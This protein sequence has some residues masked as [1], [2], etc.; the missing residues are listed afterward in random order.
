MAEFSPTCTNVVSTSPPLHQFIPPKYKAFAMPTQ[1][2]CRPR[3]LYLNLFLQ[4]TRI[5]PCQYSCVVDLASFASVHSK[6]SGLSRTHTVVVSVHSKVL[7]FIPNP[8]S[9]GVDLDPLAWFRSLEE[10][11]FSMTSMAVVLNLPLKN[12]YQII[13]QFSRNCLRRKSNSSSSQGFKFPQ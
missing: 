11:G 2:W 12:G 1:L 8:Y 5:F 13:F 7:F 4:S 9:C 3:L 6:V 10:A